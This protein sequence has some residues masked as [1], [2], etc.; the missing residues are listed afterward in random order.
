L[1]VSFQEIHKTRAVAMIHLQWHSVGTNFNA[2]IRRCYVNDLTHQAKSCIYMG[3]GSS[4]GAHF[5][6]QY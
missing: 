1:A 6:W 4:L 2:G 3:I 5:F